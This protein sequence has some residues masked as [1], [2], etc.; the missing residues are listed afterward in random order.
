VKESKRIANLNA[1]DLERYPVWQYTTGDDTG[2]VFVRPV[3]KLPVDKLTQRIVGTRVRLANGSE[4][5][6]LI[7]NLDPGNARFT[8]HFLT[9][10]IFWEGRWFHLARYH[11]H[12]YAE[13][14]PAALSVFLGLEPKDIFP[15]TYDIGKICDGDLAVICGSI[16]QEP[17]ERLSRAAIIGLAV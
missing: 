3:K 8:D 14:G 9:L 17:K 11:D 10:S 2:E 4:V 12:D 6:A 16:A 1:A 15:I 13:R 7:G 5:W